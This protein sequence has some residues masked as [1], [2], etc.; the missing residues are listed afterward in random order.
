MHKIDRRILKS[1]QA[2]QST[3]FQ[4][5]VKEG[6]D[7]ITVKNI[8]EKA[9]I[10]RKTFYLHYI[11]KYDLLDKI[12]D[13]HIEKL[14]EIC[15][16]K[17]DKGIMEGSILW[18]SYFEQHKSFFAALLK[19]KGASSFRKKLLA[20]TMGEINKKLNEDSHPIIDRHIFLK[21]LGTGTMGVLESYVLEEVDSDIEAVATQV[22]QLYKTYLDSSI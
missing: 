1:R 16:Q 5:L 10:S 9:N 2:I 18:F 4:M 19:S 22:V 12:V 8:T 3:F 11:D 14:R 20:F 21:F 15:D 13:D 6:L 17:Q 7:K